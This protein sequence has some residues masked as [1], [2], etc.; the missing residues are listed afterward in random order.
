[1]AIHIF[2][3]IPVYTKIAAVYLELGMTCMRHV[4]QKLQ[5][6]YMN[7]V[8]WEKQ[9]TLPFAAL[10]E[11]W[12]ALKVSETKLDKKHVNRVIKEFKI[13]STSNGQSCLLKALLKS[14]WRLYNVK[15]GLGTRCVMPMCVG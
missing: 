2:F 6:M 11:E 7:K 3:E 8:L 1:M 4:V 9:G 5:L 12:K 15:R 13:R 14:T 10:I